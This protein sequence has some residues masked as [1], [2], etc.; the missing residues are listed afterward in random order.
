M[1][2]FKL[3]LLCLFL[4]CISKTAAQTNDV[5]VK[6]I[7]LIDESEFVGTIVSE[8]E[9]IINF[10]TNAG[11]EIQ[12]KKQLV[13]EIQTVGKDSEKK[14][15]NGYRPG[16]HELMLMPTAYTM[17]PGQWYFSDYELF[18]LN[19]TYAASPNTH[20]GMFTLF[21]I[22][23]NFLE[24]ITLGIKQNYLKSENFQAALWGTYT[25]EASG[26]SFGNV[27]SYGE[28]NSSFHLG[29]S[30]ITGLDDDSDEWQFIYMIG[31]RVDVSRK[32]CLMIEYTNSG[33]EDAKGVLT[34]GFRFV[35][36]SVAWDIAGMKPL[37]NTG[38]LWMIPLLKA[39]VLFD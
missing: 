7:I 27:F 16:D 13:K 23:S 36:E 9:D 20:I 34:F 26:L 19:I 25:P 30:G 8:T 2:Y 33:V 32:S 29:L 31:Y 28:K 1:K 39:T 21:P 4:V 24:T 14:Q 18:F 11:V 38:D 10:R 37:E 3:F 5:E 15:K 35:G 22:T 12:I 17:E 6:K